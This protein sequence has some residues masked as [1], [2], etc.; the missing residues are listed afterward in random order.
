[1]KSW[2][3]VMR[4]LLA[5][6]LYACFSGSVKLCHCITPSAKIARHACCVSVCGFVGRIYRPL[7]I[8]HPFC[9]FC[10]RYIPPKR[11]DAPQREYPQR[12]KPA[13]AVKPKRPRG[14]SDKSASISPM[15]TM[16]TVYLNLKR[17]APHTKRRQKIGVPPSGIDT[18]DDSLP[19]ELQPK[20]PEKK[21]KWLHSSSRFKSFNAL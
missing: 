19:R 14:V 3:P 6:T 12:A 21:K 13:A 5:C 20:H 16:Q 17:L 4:S 2:K 15:S 18:K 7:D 10:R 8:C 1:M 11:F 9:V